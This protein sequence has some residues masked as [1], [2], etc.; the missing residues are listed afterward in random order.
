VF[1]EPAGEQHERVGPWGCIAALLRPRAP[2]WLFAFRAQQ[3]LTLAG[4]WKWLDSGLCVKP[5]LVTAGEG[6]GAPRGHRPFRPIYLIDT[7]FV[8]SVCSPLHGRLKIVDPL[9]Y[10]PSLTLCELTDRG[11]GNA[12]LGLARLMNDTLRD[13]RAAKLGV[14]TT[15]LG[16]LAWSS[17]LSTSVARVGQPASG[18]RVHFSIDRDS[19]EIPLEREAVAGGAQRAYYLGRYRGRVFE[20]DVCSLFPAVMRNRMYPV[21]RKYALREPSV[22][23]LANTALE[24]QCVADVKIEGNDGTLPIRDDGKNYFSRREGRAVLA[25]DDLRHALAI[26]AVASCKRAVVYESAEL[27]NNFVEAW[28]NQRHEAEDLLDDAGAKLAKSIVN[29]LW[30]KLAQRPQTWVTSEERG[31]GF[32]WGKWL[33]VD[34]LP[35]GGYKYRYFRALGGQVQE[36]VQGRASQTCFPGLA[37]CIA[38]AARRFMWGLIHALPKRSVLLVNHDALLL[39][40]EGLEWLA[41]HGLYTCYHRPGEMKVAT[42][43]TDCEIVGAGHY[44][45]GGEWHVPGI[46]IVGLDLKGE[47][48][49]KLTWRPPAL[50]SHKG[51]PPESTYIIS[52]VISPRGA[53]GKRQCRSKTEGWL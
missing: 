23:E 31:P 18:G 28:L 33:R 44:R 22:T 45:L 38:A 48:D 40:S 9:N 47:F 20:V 24:F 10:W 27:F 34:E 36:C 4:F 2:L 29:S 42:E 53:F 39:T 41:A 6:P 12:A 46:G 7:P 51:G 25:A 16:G 52:D 26:G 21:K 35:D 8:V 49:R 30:G 37:A 13:W 11:A 19:Y 3:A 5:G 32:R 15:T 14:W 1:I 50:A 43:G 17:L